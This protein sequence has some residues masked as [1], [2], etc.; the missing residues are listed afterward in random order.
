MPGLEEI[1]NG[2]TAL[3]GASNS[4]FGSGGSVIGNS[5][6]N[7][8]TQTDN[9]TVSTGS[10]KAKGSEQL[11][12][13]GAAILQLITDTLGSAGGLA[14]IFAGEQ[15]SGLF[16]SSVAS[17]E[18]GD[19]VSKLVGEIAKITGKTVREEEGE[20]ELTASASETQT[21][22]ETLNSESK[23]EEKGALENIGDFFG[24]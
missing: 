10:T 8:L 3:S 20:E 24:F 18:A 17:N 12:L 15:S 6:G 2:I 7:R 16:N 5:T 22:D 23:E 14:D 11:Q 9:T 13:E 1:G 21:I 4:I 19:L